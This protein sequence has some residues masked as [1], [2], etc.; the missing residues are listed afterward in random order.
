MAASTKL[1]TTAGPAFCAA[2][3]PVRENNP[4]P[5]IAPMPNA[6]NCAG[7]SVRL[8]ELCSAS[9]R[10]EPRGFTAKRLMMSLRIASAGGWAKPKAVHLGLE[11][12]HVTSP[13]PDRRGRWGGYPVRH[14]APPPTGGGGAAEG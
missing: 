6:T 9:F 7:P 11:F 13:C 5:I 12:L 8:S 2:V 10:I 3:I 14:S 4:A 1:S